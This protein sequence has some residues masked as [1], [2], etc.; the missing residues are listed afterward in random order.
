MLLRPL[1]IT[2]FMLADFLEDNGF[3]GARQIVVSSASS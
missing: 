2:S 1:F 3:F